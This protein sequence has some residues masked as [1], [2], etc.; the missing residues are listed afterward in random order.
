MTAPVVVSIVTSGLSVLTTLIVTS[1]MVT[2]SPFKVSSP[3][4]LSSKMLPGLVPALPV[5][6]SSSATIGFNTV[7]VTVAVSQFAG[8]APISHIS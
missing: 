1:A 2:S 5:K 4:P 7:T 3:L 8:F 6:A